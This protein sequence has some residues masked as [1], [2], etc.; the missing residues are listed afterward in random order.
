MNSEVLDFIK[1]K[2]IE[3]NKAFESLKGDD[4]LTFG[5]ICTSE[6]GMGMLHSYSIHSFKTLDG[7]VNYIYKFI[8]ETGENPDIGTVSEWFENNLSFNEEVGK[9]IAYIDSFTKGNLKVTDKF[10]DAIEANDDDAYNEVMSGLTEEEQDVWEITG[11][12]EDLDTDFTKLDS[13]SFITVAYIH[14]TDDGAGMTTAGG[15]TNFKTLGDAAEY[16]S[17]LYEDNGFGDDI[18]DWFD[19]NITADADK[20]EKYAVYIRSFED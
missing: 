11:F 1:D 19:A 3:Y 10:H 15:Y 7:L 12:L 20:P 13:K 16:I 14:T 2:L 18:S 6:D 8:E 17:E 9:Y 4:F 5:Y